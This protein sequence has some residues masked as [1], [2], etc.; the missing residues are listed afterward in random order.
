[1]L[2]GYARV[3]TDKQSL[4]LQLEALKRASCKRH[5]HPGR[6]ALLPNQGLASADRAGVARRTHT[7]PVGRG[8]EAGPGR[9][10]QEADDAGEGG[11]GPDAL[12]EGDV[13]A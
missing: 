9:R 10:A 8:A 1:M 4:H 11:I 7:R 13:P 2:I 5:H 3:S 6:T 12:H